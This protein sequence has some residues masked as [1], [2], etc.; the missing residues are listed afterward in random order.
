MK[1]GNLMSYTSYIFQKGLDC[2]SLTFA[3]KMGPTDGNK[4]RLGFQFTS[5]PPTL[6]FTDHIDV[7]ITFIYLHS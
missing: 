6:K 5:V 7:K 3:Y 2:F 1:V 4:G